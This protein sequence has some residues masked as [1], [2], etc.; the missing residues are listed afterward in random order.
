MTTTSAANAELY[1]TQL[2][3]KVVVSAIVRVHVWHTYGWDIGSAKMKREGQR[4][5][6]LYID[7]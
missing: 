6:T 7:E 3:A 1:S 2:T 5:P 4:Q